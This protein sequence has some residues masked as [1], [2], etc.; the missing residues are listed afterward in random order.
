MQDWTSGYVADIG[1]TYGYYTELNPF[2]SKLP[3]IF[4]GIVPPKSGSHCEL[5]FGQG[6][7]VNIH[8]AAGQGQWYGTDFNP[9]QAAHAQELAQ[10]SG[11]GAQLYDQSFQEFCSRQDLPEFDSIGL[12]GIWSWVSDENRRLIV[13]FIARKLKVG[14]VVYV[15]YNTQPGWAAMVPV[16]ELL[17]VH[18]S[19]MGAPGTSIVAKVEGALD[20]ALKLMETNPSFAKAN[21][22]MAERL[23]KVNQQDRS[24]LAHEYFNKDWHPMSFASMSEWMSSAKMEYACSANYLDAIETINLTQEQANLVNAISDPVLRQMTRDFCVN[25]QFRKDYWI[26]G[27]RRL[28][29][30][31]QAKLLR[32][33]RVILCVPRRDVTLKLNAGLGTVN[34][35]EAVYGPILDM[36]GD[37]KPYSIGELE[38]M[39]VPKGINIS[40]IVQSVLVL[41]SVSVLAEVQD[42]EA[43]ERAKVACAKLNTYLLERAQASNDVSFLASPVTGGAVVVSRFAQLFLLALERGH[44]SAQQCAVATWEIFAQQ[45]QRLVK[46]GKPMESDQENIEELLRQFEEFQTKTLPT[47]RALQIAR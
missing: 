27:S 8:S 41:T 30:F 7:S 18:A 25:Q 28:N 15:S 2:R 12:H 1:Y 17:T 39:L 31:E 5:G 42:Q 6:L 3:L 22:Q 14:G 21:P 13:D 44:T 36:L 37:A 9:A 32:E 26:K 47:L 24:Y 19:R 4:A 43:Q 38:A 10:A 20:F 33:T 45:K 16:R 11:S 23:K 35:S 46:E 40:Q 34:L 29:S